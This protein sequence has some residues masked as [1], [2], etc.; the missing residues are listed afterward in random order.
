MQ[1]TSSQLAKGS[2]TSGPDGPQA[3]LLTNRKARSTKQLDLQSQ[4]VIGPIL[5]HG[6]LTV[7]DTEFA[8]LIG[9]MDNDL[10]RPEPL[11]S[12]TLQDLS[13]QTIQNKGTNI[14]F[15]NNMSVVIN[16]CLTFMFILFPVLESKV[17]LRGKG[18]AQRKKEEKEKKSS[19]KT[20]GD[21]LKDNLADN[22]DSSSTTTETS[23]PDVETNIKEVH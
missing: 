10:D 6:D 13:S 14:C 17:K 5:P 11:T 1:A 22:D 2:T 19:T 12:E 23:N 20:Q 9:A 8:N 4:N 7:E 15:S 16:R 21:E 18:K 3:C